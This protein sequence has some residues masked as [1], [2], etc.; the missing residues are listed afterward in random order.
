MGHVSFSSGRRAMVSPF[1][2]SPLG[3]VIESAILGM[4]PHFTFKDVK[5][6]TSR[7]EA[8]G[9]SNLGSNSWGAMFILQG[10]FLDAPWR[11]HLGG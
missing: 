11:I 1:H 6:P 10:P 4:G 3:T 8:A 2:E 9:P 5:V 7:K